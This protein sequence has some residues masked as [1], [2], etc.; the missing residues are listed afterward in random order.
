MS[1]RTFG[2]SGIS[3]PTAS[4]WI[5]RDQVNTAPRLITPATAER[6]T[7]SSSRS[8]AHTAPTIPLTSTLLV[9]GLTAHEVAVEN[10]AE[11]PPPP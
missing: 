3:A 4:C 11:F 9:P 7:D 5:Q 6:A 10:R 8:P 2:S 1:P